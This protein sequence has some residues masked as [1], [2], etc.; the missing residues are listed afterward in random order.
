MLDVLVAKY[1]IDPKKTLMIGDRSVFIYPY[2]L[3]VFPAHTRTH[4]TLFIHFLCTLHK[5]EKEEDVCIDPRTIVWELACR[6][7]YIHRVNRV[8]SRSGCA[9][10]MTAL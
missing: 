4:C 3:N 1:N 9:A 6:R 2:S 10:T 8:N 5:E 7:C